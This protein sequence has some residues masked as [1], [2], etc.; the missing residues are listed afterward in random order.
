M[1]K[2]HQVATLL[3]LATI[4]LGWRSVPGQTLQDSFDATVQRAVQKISA[5]VVQLEVLRDELGTARA[6]LASGPRSAVVLGPDGWFVTSSA[7]L[8]KGVRA[9]AVRTADNELVPVELVGHDEVCQLA[10]LKGPPKA[11]PTPVAADNSRVPVGATAIAVGKTFQADQPTVSVGIVSAKARFSGRAVQTDAKISPRN[12]GG[13]LGNLAGEIVGVIVPLGASSSTDATNGTDW[14]DSGIGFAIPLDGILQRLPQWQARGNLRSGKS[15]IELERPSALHDPPTVA[16]CWPGSPTAKLGIKTKD[17]VLRVD[18]RPVE[19]VA[20]FQFQMERRYAGDDVS[21]EW[22][23]SEGDRKQGRIELVADL[24]EY[25]PAALG[26]VPNRSADDRLL[27]ATVEPTSAADSAGIRVGDE[28]IFV[29]SERLT[30]WEHLRRI[31]QQSLPGDVVSLKLRRGGAELMIDN[32]RLGRRSAAPLDRDKVAE[33]YAVKIQ[34]VKFTD[35]PHRCWQ[36]DSVAP[37]GARK[38]V[39]VWL[40]EPGRQ[41]RDDLLRSWPGLRA[42]DAR[43]LVIESWRDDRWLPDDLGV[44]ERLLLG[45]ARDAEIDPA[46][47]ALG[48]K[49]EGAALACLA[50]ERFRERVTG[51]VVTDVALTSMPGPILAR[52]GR[53]LLL[54]EVSRTELNADVNAAAEPV[55]WPTWTIPRAVLEGTTVDE[56]DVNVRVFRWLEWLDRL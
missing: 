28:L 42:V 8:G 52:P 17:R 40:G 47:V 22:R 11:W 32:V 33:Q 51:L 27:V 16:V 5:S 53:P 46:R 29:G 36:L 15:G 9:M 39:L 25:S 13:A 48:G 56:P 54:L 12:Y 37:R 35:F 49:K 14:Y 3:M 20:Q 6:E 41:N 38:P 21:L 18:G 1:A 43:V 45:L 30:S 55:L 44:I 10:L 4:S 31:L 26:I 2:V 19:T 50:A 24:P 34:D 23:D 7:N